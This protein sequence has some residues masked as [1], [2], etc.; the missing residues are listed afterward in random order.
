VRYRNSTMTISRLTKSICIHFRIEYPTFVERSIA[1]NRCYA[2]KNRQIS[3]DFYPKYCKRSNKIKK[4]KQFLV[5]NIEERFNSVTCYLTRK[6]GNIAPQSSTISN[7]PA[8]PSRAS[9]ISFPLLPVLFARDISN[10]AFLII[11]RQESLSPSH[12]C[13]ARRAIGE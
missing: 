4:G 8:V 1:E 9:F 6:R 10:S 5:N 13:I 3:G 2:T 11:H 7:S 12:H